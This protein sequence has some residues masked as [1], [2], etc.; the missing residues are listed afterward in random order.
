MNIMKI[1]I[2]FILAGL[3]TNVLHANHTKESLFK[4]LTTKYGNIKSIS[5]SFNNE[6]RGLNGILIAAKGNKYKLT[7]SQMDLVSNGSTIWNYQKSENKVIINNMNS[8]DTRSSLD[9]IFFRFIQDYKP[10]SISKNDFGYTLE[11]ENKSKKSDYNLVDKLLLWIDGKTLDIFKLQLISETTV[12]TW[13]VV[14]LKINPKTTN[15]TFSFTIPKD[16]EV[17]DLR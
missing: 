16:A 1:I 2:T 9:V 8:F 12:E 13:G 6:E 4:E 17:I 3:L 15:K 11:L 14:N 7:T 10:V 5:A